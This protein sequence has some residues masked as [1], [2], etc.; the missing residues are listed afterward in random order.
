EWSA[1]R[2]QWGR[3][4]GRH[5]AVAS[6]IAFIAATTYALES[7]LDLSA[8]LADAGDNDIRIEAALAKLWASEMAWLVADELV[9]IRGGRG[10]E[11]AESLAARGERAVGV[12]QLLRDLRINRIFEGSTEIMHLLVAR[13]AVDAH[14]AAAG[15]LADPETDLPARARAAVRASGFYAR[16]LPTLVAGRGQLPGGYGEVGGVGG[17]VRHGGGA[18]PQ[19]APAPVYGVG[20]GQGGAGRRGGGPRR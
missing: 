16:W 9:Q 15:E 17:G 12:E 6:K 1:A 5:G 20:P 2:V 14:L 19:R 11:P 4:V 8:H 13:E 3:P 7:M 10:Y 18:A